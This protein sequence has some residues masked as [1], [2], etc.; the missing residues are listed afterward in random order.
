MKNLNNEPEQAPVEKKPLDKKTLGI[1]IGAV[2]A[3]LVIVLVLVLV[4]GG[5]TETPDN[6]GNGDNGGEGPVLNNYTLGLG[7]SFGEFKVGEA[8]MTLAT[9]VLDKDGK[10]VLCRLDAVQNKFSAD[11]DNDSFA[12]TRLETKRELKEGYNMAT[13]G[14]NQDR[15]GDGKVLEWYL[16]AEAFENHV[17]GMT[18]EQVAAMATQTQ[19]DGYVISADEALLSAGCTIQIGE[20]KE[21]VV[22]ACND[23]F[24]VSFQ[25]EG[26][27]TLGLAANS[28]DNGSKVADDVA[29]I[30]MNVELAASVVE[31]G[32]IVASLNDAIQPQ[33][34]YEY[35]DVLTE[36]GVGKGNDVF[37]TKRELKGDYHMA[38]WGANQDRN[39]DGKVL[40]WYEQSAA[41][42]KHVIGLS[43]TEVANMATQV[44]DD[45]YVISADEALLSAGCT[46]QIT[47]IKAVVAE[48]VEAAR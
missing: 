34:I 15:N 5:N 33:I 43:G 9:V 14:A 37:K 36:K 12:F 35:G 6:G 1:I 8:N 24:K 44:Q 46:I 42:S 27:F 10:I 3:V 7:V 29:T 32:K 13:W 20:F 17:I 22:K 26:N 45:G 18:A 4:L 48:S 47:G 28:E 23:E 30:K 40:E 31:N 11:F 19:D 41:F 21:A 38:D 2:A 39:G 16:Q 25:S